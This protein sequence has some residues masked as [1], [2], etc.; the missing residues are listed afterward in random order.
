MHDIPATTPEELDTV[1]MAMPAMIVGVNLPL[2]AVVTVLKVAS[3]NLSP[4]RPT[5]RV[6][7]SIPAKVSAVLAIISG[8]LPGAQPTKAGRLTRDSRSVGRAGNERWKYPLVSE[9]V[10]VV[11]MSQVV[12]SVAKAVCFL[13]GLFRSSS[14]S[15]IITFAS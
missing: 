9:S 5:P 3:K 10:W 11:E 15:V 12:D 7:T 14:S 6:V 2:V 1:A 13:C 4:T 8:C